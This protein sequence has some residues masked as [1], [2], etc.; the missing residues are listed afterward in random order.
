MTGLKAKTVRNVSATW[1]SLIV[2]ALVSFFLSPFILPRLG[3]SAFSVWVLV[4]SLTGYFGLLD[5]GIRSSIVRYVAKFSAVGDDDQLGRFLTTSIAFYV[6]VAF[7]VL[8][9]TA[10]GSAYLPALFKIPPE[11]LRSARLLFWLAGVSV[12]VNFPL[13]VFAGVMEGLRDDR[14]V[15]R[16]SRR[17]FCNLGRDAR[18]ATPRGRAARHASLPKRPHWRVGTCPDRRLRSLAVGS[19]DQS[20]TCS[21]VSGTLHD[22]PTYRCRW[23]CGAAS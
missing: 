9:L 5:F 10:I 7:G 8:V 21:D 19:S 4:F 11:L 14:P 16:R 22:R 13:S 15:G 17:G 3:D 23:P 20:A 18:L 6:S 12:A 1:I 2:H